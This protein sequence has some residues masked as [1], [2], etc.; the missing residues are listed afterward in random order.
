MSCVWVP[1]W[2]RY[3]FLGREKEARNV[4]RQLRRVPDSDHRLHLELLEIKAASLFDKETRMAKY[5]NI[6]GRLQV[7]LRE[8]K[9]LFVLRHLNQRLLIACMLQFIQQFTGTPRAPLPPNVLTV[10]G[11]NAVIYYAP[12]MFNSVCSSA[13]RCTPA[14]RTPSTNLQ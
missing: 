6:H 1:L 4:L 2:L 9:D 10:A 14:R 12:T 7:A 13:D 8:Y 5:P 11:I 3:Y